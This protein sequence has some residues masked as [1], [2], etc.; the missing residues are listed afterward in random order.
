MASS[1]GKYNIATAKE[2][3]TAAKRQVSLAKSMLDAAEKEVKAAE[4]CLSDA[5]KRSEVIDIDQE[6]DT[7][8]NESQKNM[9]KV[10]SPPQASDNTAAGNVQPNNRSASSNTTSIPNLDLVEEIIRLMQS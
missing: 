9:R 4:K 2:R 6:P 3:L 5:E 10:S 1:A 7:A 8:A